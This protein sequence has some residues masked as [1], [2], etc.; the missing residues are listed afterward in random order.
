MILSGQRGKS[1]GE[2]M[3][4]LRKGLACKVKKSVL[5]GVMATQGCLLKNR[6]G[7]H[8]RLVVFANSTYEIY[9]TLLL[10]H[11][12]HLGIFKETNINN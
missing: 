5:L 1:D 6:F 12:N 10:S 2:P 8:I 3:T 9:Q 7:W 4:A 11:N